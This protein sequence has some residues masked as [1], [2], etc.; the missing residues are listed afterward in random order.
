MRGAEQDVPNLYHT[1]EV[2]G[3]YVTA[4][5]IIHLHRYL[6]RLGENA[7]YCDTDS[8]I[9]IQPR[10]EPLLIEKEKNWGHDLRF[11]LIRNDNEISEWGSKNYAYRVL[12]NGDDREKTV[13]KFGGITLKYNASKIVNFDVIRSMLLGEGHP[14]VNVRTENKNNRKRNGAEQWLYSPSQKIRS[15]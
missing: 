7:M 8:V 12:D 2:I 15:T 6:K 9:Y 1:N 10:G 13:C 14:A 3:A 4:E 5:A 11:A